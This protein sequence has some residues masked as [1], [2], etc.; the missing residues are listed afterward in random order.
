MWGV[1]DSRFVLVFGRHR[2][3]I[4]VQIHQNEGEVLFFSS[5]GFLLRRQFAFVV[6]APG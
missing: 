3:V 5:G 6:F 4:K 2:F 1:K